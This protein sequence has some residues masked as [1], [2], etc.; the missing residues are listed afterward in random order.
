MYILLEDATYL[1]QESGSKFLDEAASIV[2]I[3][4]GS[5]VPT[6]S[7]GVPSIVLGAVAIQPSSI[8][9]SASIGSPTL[10]G[11]ISVFPS[12][13]PSSALIGAP[14]VSPGKVVILATG[15]SASTSFGA[16]A[17]TA[18]YRLYVASILS[19]FAAGVVAVYRTIPGASI[20]GIESGSPSLRVIQDLPR[21]GMSSDA[22]R[23]GIG[24]DLPSLQASN[25]GRPYLDIS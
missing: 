11:F 24:H 3:A 17:L 10:Q 8:G 19:T 6:T 14:I 16:V 25:S 2:A 1:L 22:P 23:A 5:I 7:F 12:G 9:S 18:P 20:A 4:P 13:L 15:I 21:I